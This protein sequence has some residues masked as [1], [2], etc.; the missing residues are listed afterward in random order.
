MLTIP[1]EV[2][3]LFKV[4]GVFHNFHVHFPGG[5]ATDINNSQIVFESPKFTE[6]ICS[7][8]YLKFGLTEAPQINFDAANVPNV[9]GT[10]MFCAYE[11]DVTSLGN[12]WISNHQPSGT[13]AW[14]DPQ[15]VTLPNGL[16][17]YRVPIGLFVVDTCPRNHE[18]EP[19]RSMSAY[20]KTLSQNID[21]SRFEQ[22]R[23]QAKYPKKSV[24][25]NVS[26]FVCTALN[27]VL[28]GYTES[29]LPITGTPSATGADQTLLSD[30]TNAYTL[31]VKSESR[32]QVSGSTLASSGAA[33]F[34]VTYTKV[35]YDQMISDLTEQMTALGI[36]GTYSGYPDTG[37]NPMPIREILK[38][39]MT[40]RNM[41]AAFEWRYSQ[42]YGYE[43]FLP[44]SG[45]LFSMRDIQEPAYTSLNLSTRCTVALYSG[46]GT[47]NLIWTG[48]YDTI[49][50]P[51]IYKYTK[52]NR[53]EL[54][55]ISVAFGNTAKFSTSYGVQYTFIDAY[56]IGSILNGYL[57]L[58]ALFGR[59]GRNGS[60]EVMHLSDGATETIQRSQYRSVWWEDDSVSPIGTVRYAFKGNRNGEITEYIFGEGLSVY[61]MT[62][63]YVLDNILNGTD[64]IIQKILNESFIPN[65]SDVQFIP[66]EID[67][68]AIPYLQAGDYVEAVLEDGTTITTVI[69]QRTIS[70][71]QML[72]DELQSSGGEVFERYE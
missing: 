30:G 57:E 14:L 48:T 59:I 56:D 53:S 36:K 11:I 24:K 61:D 46:S 17:G 64:E 26:D 42:A 4:D 54:D 37:L 66:A 1:A 70:G 25:F 18:L 13:E 43:I 31:T 71:L 2:K 38:R 29:E 16:S 55:K 49:S 32:N 10:V 21:F 35:D 41:A 47:S 60:F 45:D 39:Q 33:L 6:S 72:Q 51:H 12:A 28:P 62:D 50:N 63:N 22:F 7:Q 27:K 23:Q 34:K 9:R 44:E 8:K 67:M 69:L 58:Q 5:E 68:Q 15:L 65:L 52:N 19:K 40:A 3:G 20:G